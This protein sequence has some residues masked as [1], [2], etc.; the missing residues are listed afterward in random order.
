MTANDLAELKQYVT[1]HARSQRMAP[2]HYNAVLGRIRNDDEGAEDSWAAAWTRQAERLEQAGRLLDACRHYNM[3]RFPFVDGPAR[4]DALDRCVSA[5]DR[6]RRDV[7]GIEPLD[8]DLPGGRVRCW[9][10]G[11]SG[12]E[13]LPVLLVMG[14]IV[15]VKEQW[16][17]V[18][19]NGRRLGMAGIVAELPG[20]GENTLTYGADSPAMLSQ[21]LDAIADRA[22][23]SQTYALA[24]S[25]S[26]H[27]ALRCAVDDPR[28]KGVVTVGAPIDAFFTDPEAQRSMPRITRDTLAHLTGTEPAG[29][30]DRL[31]DWALTPDQLAGLDIPV[32]Y[33]ASLRDEIIP[34][35]ESALLRQHVRH[36]DLITNDDVHG[37]PRHVREV[38]L[39]TILSVLRMRGVKGLPRLFMESSLLALQARRR[40]LGNPQ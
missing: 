13:R 39:W 30:A 3:A 24:M 35:A 26:G 23:V 20:V 22:D 27:L 14:G 7:P 37:S 17:P 9:T 33:A 28:I 15:T 32:G 34:Q 31:R 2:E 11:L 21:L 4:Q 36:L 10:S 1:V 16:A 8:L 25:F 19:A 29:I 5:F 12:T 18:L 38:G 6:W 40:L